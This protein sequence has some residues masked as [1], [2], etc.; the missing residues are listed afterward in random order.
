M[1][2]LLWHVAAPRE[3]Q[4]H[5]CTGWQ[6]SMTLF[7]PSINFNCSGSVLSHWIP[8]SF[9][10]CGTN[11]LTC[12][13]YL[14]GYKESHVVLQSTHLNDVTHTELHK[15]T[16]CDTC[17]V[18]SHGFPSQMCTTSFSWSSCS[19]WDLKSY[20]VL[21]VSLYVY[22]YLLSLTSASSSPGNPVFSFRLNKMSGDDNPYS[23]NVIL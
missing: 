18:C 19:F 3:V 12:I 15:A 21:S 7:F 5:N 2:L 23:T 20:F 4:S 10:L 6:T 14:L 8:W 22:K 16:C 9:L 13:S 17:A 11:S 1:D